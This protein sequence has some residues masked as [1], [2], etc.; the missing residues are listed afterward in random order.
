[1][2]IIKK[3]ISL[4]PFYSRTPSTV[5]FIGM[6]PGVTY[7][8]YNWGKIPYGVD[9]TKM[10]DEDIESYGV[11]AEECEN[12]KEELGQM[13]FADIMKR[14]RE[15]KNF[16]YNLYEY[17]ESNTYKDRVILNFVDDHIVREGGAIRNFNPCCDD[18]C[19]IKPSPAIIPMD[20][21]YDYYI[22]GATT[23]INV[24]LVQKANLIGSY[25]FA[26]KEWVPG[27]RYFEGDKVIYDGV[28]YKLG[29][30]P[31]TNAVI[32][33]SLK[34]CTDTPVMSANFIFNSKEQ[35]PEEYRNLDDSIFIE[36][37]KEETIVDMGYIYARMG[38]TYFVRPSW[39]GYYNDVDGV[40]YFDVL[41]DDY[42]PESGFTMTETGTVHWLIDETAVTYDSFM[43]AEC[44]SGNTDIHIEGNGEI[45]LGYENVT[46]TGATAE[47]KLINFKRFDKTVIDDCTELPG[48]LSNDSNV[49]GLQ[50]VVGTIKNI[51]PTPEGYATG[52]YLAKITITADDETIELS[53][54]DGLNRYSE[55]YT[56]GSEGKTGKIEFVYYIGATLQE[57]EDEIS[58]EG[59]DPGLIYKDVFD[60]TAV[61]T[62]VTLNNE[63]KDIVF[64]DIDYDGAKTSLTIENLDNFQ[65][66]AILSEVTYTKQ[67]ITDAGEQVMSSDFDNSEYFMEDYLLGVA[68]VSDNNENVYVDRGTAAAFER[69][70]RLSE[71]N[72]VEDLENYS[73][74]GFFQMKS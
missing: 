58:Y 68:F 7:P 70:L 38:D 56:W 29:K 61:Q 59:G 32:D 42:H 13:T 8:Y 25:T 55:V 49:L 4:E 50:Y 43:V 20:D 72:T 64:L 51:D 12:T 1:M 6:E 19:A 27:K 18:P 22:T 2:E 37:D 30:L 21:V 65:T 16:D 39:G 60:F 69:H 41:E 52:D 3:K 48:K 33:S 44:N 9:F 73:N 10:G 34:D 15:I 14:Y 5:P 67:A 36:V 47:S 74:G 24:C 45:R 17:D 54:G 63:E 35:L 53:P 57:I 71:T 40:V 62:S 46:I 26:V 23:N 31:D 11:P 28:T 66:D